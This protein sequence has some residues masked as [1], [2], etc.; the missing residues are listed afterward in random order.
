LC[1]RDPQELLQHSRHVQKLQQLLLQLHVEQR[2]APKLMECLLKACLQLHKPDQQQQQQQQEQRL[3]QRQVARHGAAAADVLQ[4]RCLALYRLLHFLTAAA[5]KQ[6]GLSASC[7]IAEAEVVE[8][9]DLL[10][11]SQW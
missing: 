7:H 5:V 11:Y 2:L 9:V 3:Q 10:R 6:R 1:Y 8:D 4:E